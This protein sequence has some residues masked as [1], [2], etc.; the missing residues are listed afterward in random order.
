LSEIRATKQELEKLFRILKLDP[1]KRE[2]YPDKPELWFKGYSKASKELGR[3]RTTLYS[4]VRQYRNIIMEERVPEKPKKTIPQYFQEFDQTQCAE[5]IRNLYY[6]PKTKDLN[7]TGKRIYSILREAWKVRGKKDPL[8]FDL[9]DFLFFFGSPKNPPYADFVDPQTGACEYNHAIALRFAMR[10]NKDADI[11]GLIAAKDPRFEAKKREKGLKRHKYLEKDEIIRVINCINEPDTL[12]FFYLG[13]LTGSRGNALTKLKAEDIHRQA[14]TITVFEEKIAKRK[15]GLVDK[16]LFDFSMSL[17]WQYIV[18]FDVKDRLFPTTLLTYNTRLHKA[19]QEADLPLEKQPLT[20]HTLKHTCVT[21][22]CL[23]DVPLD[24]VSDYT[25]TEP[26]TLLDY[27]R[28]GGEQRIDQHILGIAERPISWRDWIREW[29][30]YVVKR[31]E[32]IKQ[33]AVKVNGF[34]TAKP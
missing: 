14:N 9:N 25:R 29:H 4:W 8:T 13:I 18:D 32:Y 16:K 21:Q 28:G 20:S 12:L 10:L 33:F 5:T 7:N 22:M 30:G 31:Y 15:G 11:R 2:R 24:V 6:D 1:K 3:S 19:G 23:H 27:Y 26:Q 17:I 34:R